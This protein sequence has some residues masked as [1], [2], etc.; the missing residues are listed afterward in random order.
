MAK[1]KI[2]SV[3]GARPNFMKVAPIHRQFL[4]YPY[5]VQHQICHTGQHYDYEMSKVFFDD[6]GLPQP[7]FYLNVGSGT[8]GEQ[9]GKIMIEFEK[10]CFEAQPDLV[11]VVGDVNSTIAATLTACKLGIK[12]AHI[13]AGLR[14]FD[15]TMPEEINRIATDSICDYLF[16]TEES[17]FKNLLREGHSPDQIFFVGNTMIDSLV[18]ILPKIDES[19]I[20]TKLHL[21]GKDFALMTL[22]RPSNVDNFEQLSNIIEVIEFICYRLHLVL[23]LHPRTRKNIENFGLDEKLRS[24]SNLIITEPLGYMDFVKLMKHS[25]F[26]ITDSGGIQEET[27]YLGIPC[28][29]MRTTT[30]RPIT[31]EIGTNILVPPSKEKLTNAVQNVL[32]NSSRWKEKKIPPLW[33]GKT[34]ERIV[35]IILNKCFI[36]RVKV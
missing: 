4:R 2:I 35:D 21:D 27:T 34:S 17:G 32:D 26:V 10:V 30:E 14:S 7:D 19:Q 13:E 33:D 18:F 20:I 22:H 25:K 3:V 16:V 5:V 28:I 11:I 6:L 23:P 36:N 8:H 31:C 9:T 29:T 15:R 24:I 12:T 1:L